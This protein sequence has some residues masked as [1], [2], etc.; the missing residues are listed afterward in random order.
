[1]ARAFGFLGPIEAAA[2]M[3]MLPI[4]AALF[5]GWP[6]GPLPSGGAATATLS[7]M[8]FAAIV[9]MQMTNAFECRA[10]TDSL[11]SIGPRSNRLLL[12]AVGVEAAVL[13]GFLYLPPIWRALGHRPLTVTQWLPVLSAPWVLLI[14]EEARK[15]LVRRARR[16]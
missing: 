11:F 9:V 13:I 12:V 4:G 14:A 2:S 6:A 7:G 15:A 5:F 1:L 16:P 10:E 3:A 8:V